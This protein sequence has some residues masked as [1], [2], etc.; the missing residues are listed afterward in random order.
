[1][2]LKEQIL[3]VIQNQIEDSGHT[4]QTF[5]ETHSPI[6][7]MVEHIKAEAE[8]IISL[9]DLYTEVKQHEQIK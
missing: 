4:I 7:N 6:Q 9:C 3:K 5:S 1:M 2:S 8:E